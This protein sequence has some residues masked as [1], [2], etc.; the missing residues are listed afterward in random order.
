MSTDILS[1]ALQGQINSQGTVDALG[2]ATLGYI[3]SIQETIV[4]VETPVPGGV[5][6]SETDLNNLENREAKQ[7]KVT[8]SVEIPN[9]GIF[10]KTLRVSTDTTVRVTDV[11]FDTYKKEIL[12]EVKR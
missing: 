5:V 4:K 6:P 12:V 1:L 8:I 2:M 9:E 3:V 7:K 10:T 11:K